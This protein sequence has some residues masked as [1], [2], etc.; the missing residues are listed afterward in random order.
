MAAWTV[1]HRY[2][3]PI[4]PDYG[5]APTTVTVWRD[6][7]GGL[8]LGIDEADGEERPRSHCRTP[9]PESWAPR[10]S[11]PTD[12][13]TKSPFRRTHRKVSPMSTDVDEL[14]AALGAARAEIERLLGSVERVRALHRRLDST[15][16]CGVCVDEDNEEQI[17]PCETWRVLD[18]QLPTKSTYTRQET[19]D[20]H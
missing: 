19:P 20:G 18:A 8:V 6:N 3:T 4:D 16:W 1:L 2:V 15:P 11:R 13:P 14:V 9:P 5:G 17:W 12:Q 7:L 10:Y